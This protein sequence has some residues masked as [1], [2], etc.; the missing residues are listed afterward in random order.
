MGVDATDLQVDLDA[1]LALVAEHAPKLRAAGVQ[2][3]AIDGI[4]MHLAPHD[5]PAPVDLRPP[6]DETPVRDL[7]DPSTYGLPEGAEVPGFRRPE[8]LPRKA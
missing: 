5:P 7:D 3:L 6:E 1:K 8:D 2:V 4:T